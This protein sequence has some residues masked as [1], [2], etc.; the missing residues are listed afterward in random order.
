MANNKFEKGFVS[1]TVTSKVPDN[2]SFNS[3]ADGYIAFSKGEMR[4]NEIKYRDFSELIKNRITGISGVDG[5]VME[6]N[7]WKSNGDGSYEEISIEREDKGF[8]I[9]SWKLSKN[10]I[11]DGIMCYYREVNTQP[12]GNSIFKELKAIE[13]IVP[14]YRLHFF[15]TK[16]GK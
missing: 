4:L 3:W 2:L 15:I 6:I 7:L 16:G 13:V 11:D 10:E 12:R 8:F 14:E 1:Y 5:Y 9:Q